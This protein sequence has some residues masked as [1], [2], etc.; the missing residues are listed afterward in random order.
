[1]AWIRKMGVDS[2]DY[3]RATVLGR[4]DDHAGRALGYY[5]SRGETPLAWGGQLAFRLGLSGPVDDASYE[6]LFGAGANSR[7]RPDLARRTDRTVR[8]ARLRAEREAVRAVGLEASQ[9]LLA[10]DAA[11][12]VEQLSR[13][14]ARRQVRRRP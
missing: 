1:M 3:H 10:L 9:R 4:S 5:A 12:R 2:V 6:A 7:L 8:I 14:S 13:N 11:L